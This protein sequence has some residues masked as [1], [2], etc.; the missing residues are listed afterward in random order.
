LGAGG[1]YS[2]LILA[3]YQSS[4]WGSRCGVLNF[5][6]QAGVAAVG[7]NMSGAIHKE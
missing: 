2:G 5:G 7:G 3:G 1:D 4:L 6:F